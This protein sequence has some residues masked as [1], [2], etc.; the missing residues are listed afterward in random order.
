MRVFKNNT[1]WATG[2]LIF[3][4]SCSKNDIDTPSTTNRPP[5]V[6]VQGE[7]TIVVGQR[8]SVP[9]NY[10]DP[11]NDPITITT[12]GLPASLQ[13]VRDSMR[14]IGTPALADT[15]TRTIRVVADDGKAKT[16]VS[17]S[18]HVFANENGQK[19]FFLGKR[20]EASM[21]SITPGLQGVAVSVI[22]GGN[23]T[24]SVARGSRIIGQPN[25]P[26]QPANPFRI[27]S[28]TKSMV[29]AIILKLSEQGKI[30][31]DQPVNQ[32]ITNPLFNASVITI[33][34]LLNH[35]AGLYDHLNAN[36][37][38]S[39]PANNATKIWSLD[40]LI[41]LGNAAGPLFAPGTRY[42]YSNT[43]YVVLGK[44]IEQVT[45][46]PIALT[47][48]ELLFDPIGMP[49]ALYDDGNT[50]PNVINDLATNNR[51]YEYSPTAAGP[52]GA[53][54]SN[55]IDL[56]KFGRSVYGAHYL[57]AASVAEM[58]KNY[59]QPLGGQNY[60]L[61]TRLWNLNGILHHGH[62]GALMDYRSIVIYIPEKQMSIGMITHG[63]HANWFT[64][65]DDIMLYA[66]DAL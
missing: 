28:A 53:V 48:K 4:I 5:T 32:Y 42:A 45:G 31:L 57:N 63:V 8:L 33:R 40:E 20:L 1:L 11:D 43:G 55:A 2:I 50:L 29:A 17:F 27:A 26:L 64:L 44:V 61:G 14:I 52:A 56:A 21:L 13:F 51:S 41:A 62:T 18:L 10:S 60:G 22:N 65:V 49:S 12:P 25:V 39:H 37:F 30:G 6:A 16:E 19:Q 36:S 3:L 38:W 59:G 46:K 47:F 66:L 15:G 24:F 7:V 23:E 35:T 54:V 34:Q 9:V 58:I